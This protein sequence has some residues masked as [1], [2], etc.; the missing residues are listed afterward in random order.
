MTPDEGNLDRPQ[1]VMPRKIQQLRVKPKPLN[2]LL[3]KDD[4]ARLPPERLESTLGVHKRQPQDRPH[5]LIKDNPRKLAKRR[6]M[7]RDQAPVDRPRPD[8]NLMV[9]Q[10]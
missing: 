2:G 10:R 6:L 8:R 3:L 1:A 9:L 5:D 7:H 4:P